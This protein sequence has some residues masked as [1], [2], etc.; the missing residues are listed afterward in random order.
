MPLIPT[1]RFGGLPKAKRT[2]NCRWVQDQ[3]VLRSPPR[4]LTPDRKPWTSRLCRPPCRAPWQYHCTPCR[5]HPPSSADPLTFCPAVRPA[6]DRC[7]AVRRGIG[8]KIKRRYDRVQSAPENATSCHHATG[9]RTLQGRNHEI[10]NTAENIRSTLIVS[11]PAK[12]NSCGR[13]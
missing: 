11:F 12:P 13:G 5:S 10:D 4:P 8:A 3:P 1:H 9:R 2:R 7:G 6:G